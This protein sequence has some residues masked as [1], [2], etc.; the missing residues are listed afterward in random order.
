MAI[1]KEAIDFGKI[2]DKVGNFTDNVV[3]NVQTKFP[4][5]QEVRD[6]QKYKNLS[7][8]LYDAL[9]EVKKIKT[10]G[11]SWMSAQEYQAIMSKI[12]KAIKMGEL[13]L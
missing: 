12:D 3:D 8:T 2:R 5:F 9:V 6:V 7:K 1:F 4:E 13:M 11:N 10:A